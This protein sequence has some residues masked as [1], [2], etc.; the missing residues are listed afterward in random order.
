MRI[1][2]K[3]FQPFQDYIELRKIAEGLNLIHQKEKMIISTVRVVL[4]ATAIFALCSA[5]SLSVTAIAALSGICISIPTVLVAGAGWLL[6][7]GVTLAISSCASLSFLKL[8]LALSSLAAGYIMLEKYDI[9]H[10]GLGEMAI[11]E[12]LDH[13]HDSLNSVIQET[14]ENFSKM[15]KDIS[16][17]YQG[18]VKKIAGEN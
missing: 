9:C 4:A 2:P 13:T 7:Q 12:Y 10:L 15:K 8:G 6:Y 3:L 14:K 17:A 18:F 11:Q 16:D 5:G 1:L